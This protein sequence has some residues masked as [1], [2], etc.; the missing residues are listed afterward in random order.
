MS[1]T[2]FFTNDTIRF[3]C[4][5]MIY[6]TAFSGLLISFLI[7]L[8]SLKTLFSEKKS[9]RLIYESIKVFV[10]MIVLHLIVPAVTAQIFNPTAELAKLI[11]TPDNKANTEI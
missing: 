5:Y 2:G 6:S 4:F 1:A 8:Y 10:F 7:P 9:S 11:G 3:H